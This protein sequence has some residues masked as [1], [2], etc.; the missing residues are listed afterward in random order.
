[1]KLEGKHQKKIL[2]A[3]DIRLEYTKEENYYYNLYTIVQNIY[4]CFLYMW[5]EQKMKWKSA[6]TINKKYRDKTT[7]R[8]HI[9]EI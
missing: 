6:F 5:K 3:D 7:N 2:L 1:M 8:R 4:T 9:Y